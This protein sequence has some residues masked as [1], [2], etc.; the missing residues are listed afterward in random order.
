M[1][2]L[3]VFLPRLLLRLLHV[4]LGIALRTFRQASR[5]AVNK[6]FLMSM[7]YLIHR[8]MMTID[9]KTEKKLTSATNCRTFRL[10]NSK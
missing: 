1:P 2:I 4:Q 8:I 6:A 5:R 3:L 9:Q 10:S 7:K